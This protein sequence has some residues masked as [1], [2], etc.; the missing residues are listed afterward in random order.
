M[1]KNSPR[2]TPKFI[3]DNRADKPPTVAAPLGVV[4]LTYSR[5]EAG[6][7]LGVCLAVLDAWIASGTLR[8]SRPPGGRRVLIRAADIEAML[9]A[10]VIA[11]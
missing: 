10:S 7:A 4:R 5:A 11:A 9:A 3:R 6:E 8:A 2:K 1:P